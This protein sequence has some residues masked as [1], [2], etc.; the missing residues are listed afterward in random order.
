MV[1]CKIENCH[2]SVW[3]IEMC[4]VHGKRYYKHGDPGAEGRKR[5]RRFVPPYPAQPGFLWCSNCKEEKPFADFDRS[6]NDG[7]RKVGRCTPCGNRARQAIRHG[8]SLQFLTD[9]ENQQ[10][11]CCAICKLPEPKPWR[12]SV[13]HD[14]SCCPG[15]SSCGKCVRGLLCDTHNRMLGL[16]GDDISVLEN[17]I[18]YL[19]SFL[20]SP[21]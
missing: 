16:A 3:A 5:R 19:K 1:E 17:A 2:E 4:Y 11:N 8:M 9:L 13:D 14:H 21:Q 15:K 7:Y 10:N 20:R 18:E 6:Q 12:L